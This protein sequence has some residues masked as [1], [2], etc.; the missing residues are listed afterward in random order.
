MNFE[1]E[2]K[3]IGFAIN[4][5]TKSGVRE[6]LE[7]YI[8]EEDLDLRFK[9]IRELL[10]QILAFTEDQACA[11]GKQSYYLADLIRDKFTED[12]DRSLGK[13]IHDFCLNTK[14]SEYLHLPIPTLDPY[15]EL[16]DLLNSAISIP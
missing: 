14:A 13:L 8:V 1:T 11:R 15:Q 16:E 4:I 5:G 7:L 10:I 12:V 3:K 2:R 6:L 9:L